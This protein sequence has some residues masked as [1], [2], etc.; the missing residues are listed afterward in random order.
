MKSVAIRCDEIDDL[1]K[2]EAVTVDCYRCD[3]DNPL[4]IPRETCPNCRGT[5]KAPTCLLGIVREIR[6]TKSGKRRETQ[7]DDQFLEY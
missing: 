6:E 7:E 1:D 4:A 5:G 2:L 3:P